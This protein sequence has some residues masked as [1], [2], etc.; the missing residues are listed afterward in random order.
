LDAVRDT[1]PI[2]FQSGYRSPARLIG[3]YTFTPFEKIP[4]IVYIVD[5]VITSGSHY[6]VW[7][8][9]IHKSHPNIEVRG[10]YLARAIDL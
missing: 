7:K 8:D 9:L 3:L 10:I 4:D 1:D 2:H 6:V 5:D